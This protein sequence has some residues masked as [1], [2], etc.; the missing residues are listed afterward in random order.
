MHQLS[1]N[2]L[3]DRRLET[4]LTFLKRLIDGLIESSELFTQINFKVPSFYAHHTFPFSI[5][6]CNTNYAKNQ[7]LNRMMSIANKDQS[8][9]L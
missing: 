8:A 4:N 3:A 6:K 9:L 7:P 1:L 5:P 2:T